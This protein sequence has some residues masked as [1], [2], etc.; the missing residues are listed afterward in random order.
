MEVPV[1]RCHVAAVRELRSRR[2]GDATWQQSAREMPRGTGS[3]RAGDEEQVSE[4]SV[5]IIY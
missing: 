4:S 5:F 1:Q 2:A 3:G